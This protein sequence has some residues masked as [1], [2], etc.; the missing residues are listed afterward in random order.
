ML[1]KDYNDYELIYLAQESN[2]VAINIIYQKYKPIIYKKCYKYLPIL[3]G[4]ELC[5]LVQEC[6]IILDY[7]I[8][9]FNQD[10]NNTFYTFFNV[11]ID[12]Y[13]VS[14]YKKSINTKNKVLNESISIDSLDDENN[15]LL[16]V[17]SSNNTPEQELLVNE[18]ISNIYNKIIN[19]LTDLEE[20]VFIL[21]IQDFS[22]KEIANILDKD[23]KSIDNAMQ[24]I[25]NKIMGLNF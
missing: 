14:E 16:D 18:G 12:R 10:N 2:E 21:K 23:I 19:K 1:Y 25:K 4:I 3:K 6:Y 7:A 20:C 8:K 11:C 15:S 17:I 5:D 9:N 13:L 24:R 22:Y